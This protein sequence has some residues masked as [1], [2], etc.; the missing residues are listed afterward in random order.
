MGKKTL[1]EKGQNRR[2][3]VAASKGRELKGFQ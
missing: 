1:A 2:N 3:S